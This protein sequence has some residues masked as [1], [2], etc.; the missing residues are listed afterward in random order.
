MGLRGWKKVFS[1]DR[2]KASRVGWVEGAVKV[3]SVNA[4]LK[5]TKREMP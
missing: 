4:A 2:L 5:S 1:H 3:G